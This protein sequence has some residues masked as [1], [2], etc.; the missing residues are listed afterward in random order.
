MEKIK[1][2]VIDDN[3]KFC[4]LVKAYAEMIDEVEFAV[5]HLTVH[6]R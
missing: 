3:R 5:L 1:L 4:C 6:R 2:M